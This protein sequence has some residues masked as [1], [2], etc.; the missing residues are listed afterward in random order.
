M[1]VQQTKNYQHFFD[2]PP[3]P[4]REDQ[5][6]RNESSFET[7]K[8]DGFADDNTAGTLFEYESLSTLKITLE[9]FASFSGLRCNTDKTV[10]MQVGYKIPISDEIAGLGFNFADSIHILGMDIDNEL[11]NL[12][13]NFDKTIASLK[14]S[15]DYWD[16]YYLTL[17]G[18]IN[19][20]KSLLFPL[21]LYLGCFIM[22]SAKIKTNAM[23]P[24]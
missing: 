7:A 4:D 11:N 23:S 14:K 21:V 10:I 3:V 20:I 15:I 17:P 2:P 19:V 18:R 22:P 16:R 6:F 1:Y 12:D 5:K 9:K 13:A 8:C 24:G